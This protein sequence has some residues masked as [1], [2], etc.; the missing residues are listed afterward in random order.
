VKSDVVDLSLGGDG[1]V[2]PDAMRHDA[3]AYT[4]LAGGALNILDIG[5][6]YGELAYRLVN[7]SPS[8]RYV[9][10]DLADTLYL[11]YG[12]LA[13]RL[14]DGAVSLGYDPNAPI[15]LVPESHVPPFLRP[16]VVTNYRSWG[17]M[18]YAD[19]ARYFGLIGEWAP[20]YVVHE[21]SMYHSDDPDAS[22]FL[23]PELMIY[24]Y[25]PLPGYTVVL[26]APSDW[27]AGGGRYVRQ[28]L[29]RHP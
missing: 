11:A 1:V 25:P 28:V 26:S 18:C 17:E 21:N 13:P 24:D 7:R 12:Y 16:D 14:P 22:V 4:L 10:V 8:V 9:D 23:H 27:S 3:E 19:V 6:G 2:Y 29:R 20:R 15:S 5:G